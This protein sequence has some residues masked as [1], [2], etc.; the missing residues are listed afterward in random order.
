M[1]KINADN[2]ITDNKTNKVFLSSLI[3]KTSGALDVDTRSKLKSKILS[4][5]VFPYTE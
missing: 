4:T 1:K 3:D 5:I 2:F